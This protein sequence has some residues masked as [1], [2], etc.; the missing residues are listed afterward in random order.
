VDVLSAL[1]M[2]IATALTTAIIVYADV[3]I[4]EMVTRDLATQDAAEAN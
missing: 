1:Q 2:H 4:M 3:A